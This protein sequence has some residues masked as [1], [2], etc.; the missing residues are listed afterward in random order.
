MLCCDT[1]GVFPPAEGGLFMRVGMRQSIPAQGS[2][3]DLRTV[4][5]QLDATLRRQHGLKPA[6]EAEHAAEVVGPL[7]AVW[8]GSGMSTCGG[9]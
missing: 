1:Q 9:A 3:S 7:A 5:D 4:V 8:N 2:L 6:R